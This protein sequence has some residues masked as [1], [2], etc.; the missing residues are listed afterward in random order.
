M[1]NHI[2]D[3]SFI[4]RIETLGT[5]QREDGSI[6]ES[7]QEKARRLLKDIGPEV[8][9]LTN[10]FGQP[11][12]G[13]ALAEDFAVWTDSGLE[14]KPDFSRSRDTLCPPEDGMPFFLLGHYVS[15]MVDVVAG[16]W[17]VS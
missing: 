12:Y 1:S 2:L 11:E 3:Q 13:E 7:S 17:S 9:A 16:E 15:L 6:S 14:N 5:L 4:I 8:V 10:Q